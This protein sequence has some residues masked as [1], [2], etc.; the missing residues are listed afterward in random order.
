MKK[1]VSILIIGLFLINGST[2]A[3]STLENLITNEEKIEEIDR[4]ENIKNL[5]NNDW[6][7]Y[8][9]LNN[10][11]PNGM[12]DFDQRQDNWKDPI[13]H[14]YSFCGPTAIANIF[15]YLDSKFSNT[16]GI[17]GDG[18]DLFPLVQDYNA[19][20]EPN[21]GPFSDD[22]NFNNVDDLMS[23]WDQNEN[24]FGNELIEKIAWY[25]DTNSCRSGDHLIGTYPDRMLYGVRQWFHD[26]GLSHSFDIELYSTFYTGEHDGLSFEQLTSFIKNGSYAIIGLYVFNQNLD[27]VSAHWVTVAG[28]ASSQLNIAI[29]NPVR[30]TTNPTFDYM[31]HND[32]NI[33]SHDIYTINIESPLPEQG[34]WY[35]DDY[36]LNH[37]PI[38]V[39]SLIISQ[40]NGSPPIKPIRPIGPKNA[41]FGVEHFYSSNTLDLDGDQIYYLFDWGDGTN[42]GWIGPKKSGEKCN[43]S[44]IWDNT[45]NYE[46]KV[47]AK[48]ENG[49]ESE[50]SDPLEVAMPKNKVM[51]SGFFELI[52]NHPILFPLLRLFLNLKGVI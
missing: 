50:W 46:I 34:S 51:N 24:K 7:W 32:A 52:K 6:Y 13:Y 21:P 23:S 39:S 49:A 27:P 30:D 29:S 11:A 15:W 5:R 41:E 16:T 17:P 48:D 9:S 43:V 45:G 19:L 37:Y 42:S 1:M 38:V 2:F 18:N 12:P 10:Y 28:I 3:S 4:V 33:V 47:K 31:L 25:V 36:L 20:S 8:P 40:I 14:S 35:L 22:H 26:V 44:H